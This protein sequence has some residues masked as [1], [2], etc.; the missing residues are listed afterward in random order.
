MARVIH[1]CMGDQ[2]NY[3]R[4]YT[5]QGWKDAVLKAGRFSVFEATAT[6]RKALFFDTLCKDHDV[7]VDIE[8]V[9]FPWTKVSRRVK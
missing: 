2:I 3:P 7:E 4:K 9:G 6:S 5:Y 8:S 1:I